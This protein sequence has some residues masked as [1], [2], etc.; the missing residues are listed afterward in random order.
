MLHTQTVHS[1]VEVFIVHAGCDTICQSVFD[2]DLVS[3]TSEAQGIGNKDLRHLCDPCAKLVFAACARTTLI[4]FTSSGKTNGTFRSL[5]MGQSAFD[6]KNAFDAYGLG[7]TK[8]IKDYQTTP[9]HIVRHLPGQT[10]GKEACVSRAL[11]AARL[12]DAQR[13]DASAAPGVLL[14]VGCHR[15]YNSVNMIDFPLCHTVS[16]F[17]LKPKSPPGLQHHQRWFNHV[18]CASCNNAQ[19]TRRANDPVA[20]LRPETLHLHELDTRALAQESEHVHARMRV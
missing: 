8:K 13:I 4:A 6:F 15:C 19:G 14:E 7:G 3:L 12:F 1:H 9:Q 11:L 20:C 2:N 5:G 10:S 18:L 17:Y 16:E